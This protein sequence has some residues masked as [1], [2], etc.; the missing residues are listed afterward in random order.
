MN[1]R[2]LFTPTLT[3]GAL[4]LGASAVALL[5]LSACNQ[6]DPLLRDGVYRPQHTNRADLTMMAANPSDLVHG[7]GVRTTDGQLAAAAIQR[8]HDNKVKKLPDAGI[9]DI[10]VKSQ[11]GN[12]E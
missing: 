10:S 7:S 6:D 1:G 9:S 3:T 12:A 8:L 5:A 2:F 11:G 4:R